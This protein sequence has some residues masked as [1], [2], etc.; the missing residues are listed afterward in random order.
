MS[1]NSVLDFL[2]VA[3][4]PGF[5]ERERDAA[6]SIPSWIFWSSQRRLTQLAAVLSLR[7]NSVLDFLVVAT[8]P[9]RKFGSPQRV[10]IPS[11]IF[12]SSQPLS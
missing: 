7:F 6:V 8:S 4:V 5:I 2:V 10:S 3:T 1:F 11:W 12:W 9:E